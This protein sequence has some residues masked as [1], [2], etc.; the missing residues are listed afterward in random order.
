MPI[1]S[2]RVAEVLFFGAL[3][4]FVVLP[5][6]AQPRPDGP[7]FH[8]AT[9]TFFEARQHLTLGGSYRMYFGKRG[10]GIEPEYSAMIVPDH[11]DHMLAYAAAA[12]LSVP[13]A[14][15]LRPPT[16]SGG[17]SPQ[18]GCAE[19]LTLVCWEPEHDDAVEDDADPMP[20][21]AARAQIYASGRLRG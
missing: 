17:R 9:A 2:R 6:A 15:A 7:R 10:W 19:P 21:L 5:L 16:T 18:E 3:A 20:Q 11:T 12:T 1:N 14:V 8:P 4:C 13:L